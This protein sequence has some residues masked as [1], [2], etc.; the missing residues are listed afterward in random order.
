MISKDNAAINFIAV[1]HKR[2]I[3]VNFDGSYY[4]SRTHKTEAIIRVSEMS[5]D[6]DR[7][8]CNSMNRNR[9]QVSEMQS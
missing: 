5:R 7:P 1:Q 6:G 9:S 2:L 8:E 4:A 3:P